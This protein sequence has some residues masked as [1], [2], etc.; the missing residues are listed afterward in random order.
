MAFLVVCSSILEKPLNY[1]KP[2]VAALSP[3]PAGLSIRSDGG[4][5][6]LV[7]HHPP[8]TLISNVPPTFISIPCFYSLPLPPSLFRSSLLKSHCSCAHNLTFDITRYIYIYIYS[9]YLYIFSASRS[10]LSGNLS[11]VKDLPPQIFLHHSSSLP[12]QRYPSQLSTVNHP[13]L[14]YTRR[15]HSSNLWSRQS[16]IAIKS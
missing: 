5:G 8:P 3:V 13:S 9:I 6:P 10:P 11:P 14:L 2:A 15:P 16:S 1:P 12:E 4:L 7:N